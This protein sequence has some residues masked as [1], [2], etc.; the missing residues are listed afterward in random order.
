M[1]LE[2]LRLFCRCHTVFWGFAD[3][4]RAR[5]FVV[6]RWHLLRRSAGLFAVCVTIGI[7]SISLKAQEV[8]TP[9]YPNG[10][11]L[12]Q[13]VPT[14]RWS[15]VPGAI[16]YQIRV[17]SPNTSEKPGVYCGDYTGHPQ[18]DRTYFVPQ[19]R[20]QKL[21]EVPAGS[22]PVQN[23]AVYGA[24]NTLNWYTCHPLRTQTSCVPGSKS[25]P[26]SAPPGKACQY[27]FE[28][29]PQR[30][31]PVYAHPDWGD[32]TPLSWISRRENCAHQPFMYK[33]SVRAVFR[34]GQDGLRYGPW[35]DFA[36]FWYS[37]NG[38]SLSAG[39]PSPPAPTPKP[40]QPRSVTFINNSGKTLYIFY[41]IRTTASVDCHQYSKGGVI[42]IGSERSFQIPPPNL[43][44]FLFE[45]VNNACSFGDT[46]YQS[47]AI[48][49]ADPTPLRIVVSRK[50][51]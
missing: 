40:Q 51:N 35:S 8:P 48:Q 46:E 33:W 23:C 30:K 50:K 3:A 9:I 27:Q 38:A 26:G 39:Q 17:Q 12:D 29:G 42:E 21:W 10:G 14:Y 11:V 49:G 24:L 16:D 45:R 37:P 5:R 7:L 20:D 28:Y 36:S 6:H 47:P 18:Q 31:K 41:S 43:G 34:N 15:A 32:V 4:L 25:L 22:F 13:D 2:R 19:S 1:L 44:I